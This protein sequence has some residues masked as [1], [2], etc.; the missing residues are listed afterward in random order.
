MQFPSIIRS[1]LINSP[2]MTIAL[3]FHCNLPFKNVTLSH[4]WC[5]HTWQVFQ[6]FGW[7]DFQTW[8]V[9]Y[10]RDFPSR[11]TLVVHQKVKLLK[12]FEAKYYFLVRLIGSERRYVFFTN[13][14]FRSV[15]L[16]ESHFLL[17]AKKKCLLLC[18]L[19]YVVIYLVNMKTI[20]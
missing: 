13:M 15:K 18:N 4:V 19:P 10:D 5:V 16:F 8:K 20:A 6:T 9:T 1:L 3:T 14:Y 2:K 12:L 7:W 11:K 17:T